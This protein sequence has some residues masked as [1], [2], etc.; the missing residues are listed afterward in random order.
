M[1]EKETVLD[2]PDNNRGS[3]NYHKKCISCNDPCG[4]AFTNDA[5]M[6]C[7][8]ARHNIFKY[9]L[10]KVDLDISTLCHV[11]SF[12]IENRNTDYMDAW[13]TH[14][15]NVLNGSVRLKEIDNYINI[16]STNP[17]GYIYSSKDV[18][19]T[20][21]D[22]D[23]DS[24]LTLS[25]TDMYDHLS[26]IC[27]GKREFLITLA[28]SVKGYYYVWN[29][30][31]K[32][33]SEGMHVLIGTIM[34]SAY[35]NTE[36]FLKSGMECC[37]TVT[38][39]AALHLCP[40]NIFD[41][42]RQNGSIMK[43]IHET[44]SGKEYQLMGIILRWIMMYNCSDSLIDVK[45]LIMG[46]NTVTKMEDIIAITFQNDTYKSKTDDNTFP[47]RYITNPSFILQLC[48]I[49]GGEREFLSLI[50]ISYI[51]TVTYN[52]DGICNMLKNHESW[53]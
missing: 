21:I 50:D 12:V 18:V 37:T 38:I 23:T 45:R 7:L 36:W 17:T 14:I 43:A 29:T 42:L 31:F 30:A 51:H 44:H 6:L 49:V 39:V 15:L 46:S 9:L 41:L 11:T 8:L 53:I 20:M 19:K 13:M 5:R 2:I 34:A 1:N 33:R 32:N 35:D 10:T 52:E 47:L 40:K 48:N 28:K 16:T 24:F 25:D 4:K 26:R 22:F 27:G 3:I